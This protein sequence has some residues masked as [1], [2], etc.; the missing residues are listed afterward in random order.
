[1]AATSVLTRERTARTAATRAIVTSRYGESRRDR[2][3]QVPTSY[4]RI[5]HGGLSMSAGGT[6]PHVCR[7]AS[8]VF[9]KDRLARLSPCRPSWLP[10]CR[11]RGQAASTRWPSCARRSPRPG[12]TR[13]R[14]TSRPARGVP[15]QLAV[16]AEGDRRAGEG[17][18]GGSRF[19]VP[20]VVITPAELTETLRRGCDWGRERAPGPLPHPVGRAADQAGTEAL[21]ARSDRGEEVRVGRAP[22]T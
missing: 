2:V 8:G 15:R 19:E 9:E 7:S 5:G 20:V 22:C 3:A 11:Q 4:D 16:A 12:S 14:P 21:E 17:D 13:W 10:A 18:A 6:P 1:M